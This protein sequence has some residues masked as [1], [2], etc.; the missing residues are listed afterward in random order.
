MEDGVYS[1]TLSVTGDTGISIE[2]KPAFIRVGALPRIALIGSSE[3]A[4]PADDAVAG[5]LRS[6]GY[7][8]TT[9]DDEPQNRP[10]AAQIAKDYG[11]VVVSSTPASASVAGQFRTINIPMIFWENALL[12]EGRES[13]TDN[14]NVV[15]DSTTINIVKHNHPITLGLPV[16][17]LQVFSTGSNMSVGIGNTGPGTHVLARRQGSSDVALMVAEAGA[18]V[19]DGYV[20][21]AR[22]V[23]YF[24]E[25]VSWLNTTPIAKQIL[26]RSVCWAM[27][28][29]TPTVVD[30]PEDASAAV[31]D[32]VT[33]S[34]Q[35]EGSSPL[36]YR[37]RRAGQ[38][39]PGATTRNFTIA[40]VA[41]SDAGDYDVMVTNT[42]GVTTSETATLTI[43]DSC[44]CDW[45][46]SGDL[47]SQDF[48]DF[49]AAFFN[50]DA[51]FNAS[52][53]TDSQDFFD[54]LDCFFGGC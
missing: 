27:N 3:P 11:L 40:S 1:V 32:S 26:E 24:I 25:D 49:L 4:T 10:S 20:T 41:E 5:Y 16:G 34:A 50:G 45:D 21:P 14:G 19:A 6:L 37:W 42:C 28:V 18:A 35:A 15:A 39:I 33:F 29:V 46:D 7:D 23:F 36:M 30:Q 9:L 53:S 13:L 51:D 48:F 52:G 31:G 8:V 2:E 38:P 44:A 17:S 12:R 54:F 43:I 22:R 47:S